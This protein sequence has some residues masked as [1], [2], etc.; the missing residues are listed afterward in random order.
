RAKFWPTSPVA[1]V[2]NTLEVVIVFRA[3]FG[4]EPAAQAR[5][6]AASSCLRFELRSSNFTPRSV[7]TAADQWYRRR[8]IGGIRVCPH[9]PGEIQ[10][11]HQ[12][13]VLVFLNVP[14]RSHLLSTN[15]A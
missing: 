2:I 14:A 9:S 7:V 5:D 8:Q 10:I 13:N 1:P 12:V 3:Y 15:P 4:L 11:G 6:V